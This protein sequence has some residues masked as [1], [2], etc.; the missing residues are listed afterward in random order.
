LARGGDGENGKHLDT[1]GLEG[2]RRSRCPDRIKKT[3]TDILVLLY[4]A[5]ALSTPHH[6]SFARFTMATMT[7]IPS[8]TLAVRNPLD[9]FFSNYTSVVESAQ[10]NGKRLNLG[11]RSAF[12]R[13][14]H[15]P[16][17][18]RLPSAPNPI[19]YS[20]VGHTSKL[21]ERV[22]R[23]SIKRRHRSMEPLLWDLNTSDD[24]LGVT[25]QPWGQSR[26][27]IQRTPS[28]LSRSVIIA[29]TL[30][31]DD[32]PDI[33]DD[34]DNVDHTLDTFDP[35]S[36]ALDETSEDPNRSAKRRKIMA[37]G[38][39]EG[40]VPPKDRVKAGLIEGELKVPGPRRSSGGGRRAD[41]PRRPPPLE[42]S[43]GNRELPPPSA[44]MM[45]SMRNTGM[46]SPVVSGFPLHQADKVT[47]DAV[48]SRTCF[49]KVPAQCSC[50]A[51]IFSSGIPWQS[52]T[53]KGILS[54]N[55]RRELFP[56]S[57]IYLVVDLPHRPDLYLPC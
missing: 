36:L 4:S 2:F 22:K 16:R 24:A 45:S 35:E 5:L 26:P 14:P 33:N 25:D 46:V 44:G 53:L 9:I 38:T 13:P 56:Q 7:M 21:I 12:D 29:N 51:L 55:A 1:N 49:S 15:R 54:S 17:P 32:D 6:R 50:P 43:S 41:R 42:M 37:D 27:S 47:R 52:K 34:D 30:M 40:S 10:S 57:R 19:L 28:P 20:T 18:L 31:T 39:S 23:G 11:R 8:L 48:S 3:P